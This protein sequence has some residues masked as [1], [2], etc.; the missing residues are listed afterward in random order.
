MALV[1]GPGNP[2]VQTG[3]AHNVPGMDEMMTT[4]MIRNR[5]VWMEFILLIL[6][7]NKRCIEYD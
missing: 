1:G 2:L 5:T 7:E 4:E 3:D 6:F